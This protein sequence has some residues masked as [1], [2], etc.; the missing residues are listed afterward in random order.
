MR[1]LLNYAKNAAIAYS[2]KTNMPDI[3]TDHGTCNMCSNMPHLHGNG[4]PHIEANGVSWPPWK[5]GWKIKKRKHAKSS[6]FWMEC[7]GGGDKIFFASD[8]KGALTPLTKILRTLVYAVRAMR[9]KN[10]GSKRVST[11]R[12]GP[13]SEVVWMSLRSRGGGGVNIRFIPEKPTHQRTEILLPRTRRMVIIYY[14]NFL[15]LKT[16]TIRYEV[17]F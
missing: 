16:D 6:V 13:D 15:T 14:G 4:R 3:W 1:T 7:G 2:H 9:P 17:L 10:K 8:G 11:R 12:R 5:N